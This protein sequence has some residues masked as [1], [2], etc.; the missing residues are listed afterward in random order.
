MKQLM[1]LMLVF[2]MS[3][4][5]VEAQKISKKER[6]AQAKLQV[7]E[8]LESGEFVFEARNAQTMKGRQVNL[9]SNYTFSISGDSVSA[10]LPYF[11]RAYT[12]P[13][14]G[15]GGI[16]FNDKAESINKEYNSKKHTYRYEI[17][18]KGERDHFNL[19]LQ[20]G[21]TGFSSLS[22]NCN[23]RQPISFTGKLKL[24]E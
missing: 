5:A 10:D 11:G 8:L 18:V 24:D 20:I 22:V 9:T 17:D 16:K 21:E 12:A 3:F 7:S 19:I 15:E 14:G 23:N 1:T 13:Y 2:L 6:E 4:S